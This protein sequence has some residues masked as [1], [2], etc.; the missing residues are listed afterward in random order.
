[1][2]SALNVYQ[3]NSVNIESPN[4]LI[5]MLYEGVLRF[6]TQA[7]KSI[8]DDDIEKQVYW[9][10]RVIDIFAELIS[11]LDHSGEQE[12]MAAYLEGLYT[13]Q[14]QL[15]TEANVECEVEKLDIVI[16]VV[17][18]LLDAWREETSPVYS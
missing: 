1:M 5:E 15:L 10:N 3:Q 12:G 6:I 7:K 11:S 4:K 13:Y 18:G 9:I 14:I 8:L 2:Q 17:R 16:K